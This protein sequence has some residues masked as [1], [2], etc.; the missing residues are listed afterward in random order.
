MFLERQSQIVEFENIL[1]VIRKIHG[2]V[3]EKGVGCVAAASEKVDFQILVSCIMRDTW[4]VQVTSA[5][6][7]S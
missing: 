7:L 1:K 2:F 3:K 6:S 5:S 4:P